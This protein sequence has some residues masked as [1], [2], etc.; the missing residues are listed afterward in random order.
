MRLLASVIGKFLILALL[1]RQLTHR[2][3]D[4]PSC[5]MTY[6]QPCKTSTDQN[7]NVLSARPRMTHTAGHLV[8]ANWGQRVAKPPGI[9]QSPA[10]L[11]GMGCIQ[12]SSA[13]GRSAAWASL[14]ETHHLNSGLWPPLLRVAWP[15]WPL[16]QTRELNRLHLSLRSKKVN[17]GNSLFLQYL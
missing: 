15:L 17:A 7:G 10:D 3:C 14:S 12:E 9:S 8:L 5:R 16:A 4:L 2:G 13:W 6:H 11:F 1:M